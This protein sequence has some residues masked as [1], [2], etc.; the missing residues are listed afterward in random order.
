MW[1]YNT[2][3]PSIFVA[4]CLVKRR[5]NFRFFFTRVNFSCRTQWPRGLRRGS[6]AARLLRLWVR[7][8]RGHGCLSVVSVV[9]CR[10]E[11]SATGRSLVQ[12][13]PTDS[14]VTL[15]VI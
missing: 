7:I 9:C 12:K 13:S 8:R 14:D 3:S 10:V 1:I 4:C 15:G 11:V 5:E 6:A 2:T